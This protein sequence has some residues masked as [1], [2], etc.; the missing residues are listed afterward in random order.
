M[1][2]RDRLKDYRGK[3]DVRR[4]GEPAGQSNGGSDDEP[5]L[6][7]QCHEVVGDDA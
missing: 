5:P 2:K 7:I 4:S 6:V 3:R 1:A